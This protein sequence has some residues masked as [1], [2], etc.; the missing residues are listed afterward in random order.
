MCNVS[1]WASKNLS[2]IFFVV[3]LLKKMLNIETNFSKKELIFPIQSPLHITP[4]SRTQTHTRARTHTLLH[5]TH[6]QT[7]SNTCY[8]QLLSN[9][10]QR[11]KIHQQRKKEREREGEKK[12]NEMK[13][14]HLSQTIRDLRMHYL[15]KFACTCER[16]CV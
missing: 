3:V 5:H 4:L 8:M 14:Q 11:S 9:K 2:C 13:Q 1:E 15:V 12:R 6:E 7:H 10:L 16:E